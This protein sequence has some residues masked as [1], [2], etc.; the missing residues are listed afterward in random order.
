MRARCV[1]QRRAGRKGQT[2]CRWAEEKT[3]VLRETEV[4]CASKFLKRE[5]WIMVHFHYANTVQILQNEDQFRA[6]RRREQKSVETP[7]GT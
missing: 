2:A 6:A 4:K 7:P 3:G 5:T 1:L